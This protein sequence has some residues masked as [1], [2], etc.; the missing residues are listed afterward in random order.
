MNLRE[1]IRALKISKKILPGGS[2]FNKSNLFDN[3]K[4][5]YCLIKGNKVTV[6]D[7]DGNKYIDFMNGLGCN[8]LGYNV[9]FINNAIV[10]EINNGVSLPLS[11]KLEVEVAKKLKKI[12]PSAEMV[13]F[14]KNGS[15]VLTQAVK[16][17][18]YITKK[19]HVLFGGYHGWHDWV[20]SQTSRSGGIPEAE[21]K[22][23]HKFIFNDFKSIYKLYKKLNGKVACIVMDLV[24]RYYAN[25]D[26]LKKVRR[27]CTEKKIILVF[28]EIVTGFR[29]HKGGAQSF[30]KITPDLSCFGKAM[31]NGMPISTL[32]GKKKYMKNFDHIFY[33]MNFVSEK[34]SLAAANVTLDFY[35]KND[36]SYNVNKKGNYLIK[37][38]NRI[39]QK[40][41]LDNILELQGMPSRIIIGFKNNLDS[42]FLKKKSLDIENLIRYMVEAFAKHKILCNLS[43]FINYQ[44]KL[45]DLDKFIKVFDLICFNINLYKISLFKGNLRLV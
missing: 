30:F 10:K 37:H 16:L 11:N 41:N 9:K 23:S 29:I 8:L 4:T 27:F 45:K 15:D 35:I 28:D 21:K 43:I 40:Y 20:I 38:L 2:T 24:A 12:I 33:A 39:I 13:R 17:S 1:N 7:I 26:F 25:K 36:V 31:G 3:G 42:D 44:H 19:D 18:R 22:L 34:A 6:T 5:P 32:V 14:G